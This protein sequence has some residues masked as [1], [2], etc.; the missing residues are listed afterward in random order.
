MANGRWQMEDV[1][2]KMV[3]RKFYQ[4]KPWEDEWKMEKLR[5]KVYEA[6]HN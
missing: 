6:L 2:R 5:M 1:K 3:N 4:A